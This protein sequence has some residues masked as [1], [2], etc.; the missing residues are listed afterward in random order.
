MLIFIHAS[1]GSL[2]ASEHSVLSKKIFYVATNGNDQWTGTLPIPASSGK[3]GPFA[4]LQRARNAIR[5]L[6]TKGYDGSFTVLVRGGV[7]HL[8]ETL[9]LDT[10]DSG[11]Q[12]NPFVVKA[13][14][15]ET[16]VF[17]GARKVY[18]FQRHKNH[19]YKA[20]LK[21]IIKDGYLPRQL[22]AGGKR[23]I[24]AR[25]PNFEP[26]DPIGG[27]FMY[28][29]G[30]PEKGSKRKIIYR[31]GEVIHWHGTADV[32]VFIFPGRNYG[33]CIRPLESIDPKGQ[34][35]VLAK[36]AIDEILPGNRFYFQNFAEALDS[37]GEWFYDRKTGMLYF[38]PPTPADLD[39]VYIP[40]LKTLIEIRGKKLAN[41]IYGNPSFITF[42]G[43]TLR[44][45]DGNAFTLRGAKN[46]R[47]IRNNIHHAGGNGIE[48][49]DGM[50]N[51]AVGNDIYD[52]GEA[53]IVI[54]GGDR[55]TLTPA[56]HHAI[57]NYIHDTGVFEKGGASGI[58]CRG[59]GHVVS[60]NLIHSMPRVGIWLDGNDHLIEYNHIHHANRE[61]Q[62]SGLIYFGQVDWT[63]RGNVI[64]YN[65]LHDSGGYGRYEPTEPFQSPYGTFGIYMDDWASGT[66]VY[67]NIIAN[68]V[69]GAAFV[70]S[71]RDNIIENNIIIEGGRLGQ[72]IYSAW[73]PNNPVSQKHLPA[74]FSKVREMVSK[75]PQLSSITDIRTGAKMSGNRFERNIVVYKDPEAILYGIYNDID[76]ATTVSDFNVI[77][78]NGMPLTIPFMKTSAD[79]QWAAWK[80]KGFDRHSLIADPMF[81]DS[82]NGDYSLRPDSPA[83]KL[84]FNPIPFEKIG[85]YK[86]STR[87]SWPLLEKVSKAP[88]SI[89]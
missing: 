87:A 63:K 62:D 81:T 21:G 38:W 18:G 23:Q 89:H 45:C 40:V 5:E 34:I 50:E 46:S 49:I 6:R 78:H 80:N 71:G 60:H 8:E 75:Y 44:D 17:S 66:H 32:E 54:S 1:N 47:I 52:I 53:G 51:T 42:E 86:D 85:P 33:N 16:P 67:G 3:D 4:T 28:A 20:D 37:P 39:S 27:G 69:N 77:D 25:Y 15:R 70:H 76:L 12:S 7:Y 43:F 13:Y 82:S 24:M 59:V 2:Q 29:V 61:T 64:R 58:L 83:W 74:M 19:I 55:T 30:V 22:F 9:V 10:E 36:D 57:N 73:L 88:K 84:G 11:L 65:Y 72:M 56:S 35:I 68:T 48:I 26:L 79:R 14:D 41:R 31:A